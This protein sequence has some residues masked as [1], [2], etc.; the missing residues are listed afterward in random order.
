MS[1]GSTYPYCNITTDLQLAFKDIEDFA[2]LD[3]L[4]GFTAVSGYDETFSKH[5]TGYYGVV[6]EDGIKLTE[7]TSIATVQANASSFWYDSVNDILYI[8]YSDDDPDTH[9]ITAG[10]EDW[11]DLKTLCR[12]DAMEEVESYL[13][14]RYSRPLPFAKNSYN[15][16]KYD[17]DLVKA[18][19]FVTVR[20]IIEHRDPNN[21]LIELFWKR[22]YSSEEPYGLLWEY[23]EG[24]RA[25]SFQTTIDDFDGRLEV[26]NCASTG[27]VQ[28]AGSG[29]CEDHRIMRI[30]IDTAGAVETAT[31]KISDDNGLTWYS[32]KNKTYYNY[33]WLRYGIWIRFDGVFEVDDEWLIEIAGRSLEIDKN[34]GIGSITIKRNPKGD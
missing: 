15:S 32:E 29:Q 24:K 10:T 18:T 6:Y 30:K 13:D 2:G 25:F 23:R 22:V 17:S 27:R 26:I 33:T 3:T 4:T 7:Q 1:Q 12:N 16:A 34:A 20:K 14:S 19:A 31:Y 11:N 5:N 8:H 21:Q 28:I 9:T